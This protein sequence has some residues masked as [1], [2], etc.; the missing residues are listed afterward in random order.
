MVA[1]VRAPLFRCRPT[2][3][4]AERRWRAMG[5]D[6]QVV[7][8]GVIDQV[9]TSSAQR[10]RVELLADQAVRRVAELEG[11]WSRFLPTSEISV[12]N[13]I[14]RSVVSPETFALVDRAVL[15]WHRTDGRFDPT[16]LRILEQLGYNRS[17]DRL[18]QL[19]QPGQD[20]VGHDQQVAPNRA[21]AVDAPRGF[22]STGCG[23]IVLDPFTRTIVLPPSSIDNGPD[24]N[25]D[26]V[27]MAF[28]PGGIAKGYAADLVVEALLDAGAAGA[29]VNLGGDLRVEGTPPSGD[30]WVL[31]VGEAAWSPEPLAVLELERGAVATSTPLRRCWSK[32]SPTYRGGAG[33]ESLQ[34]H[35][36]LDAHTNRPVVNGPLLVTTI[37]GEAWWAEAA[38]TALAATP[39]SDH[40]HLRSSIDRHAAATVGPGGEIRF[41]GG[42]ERFVRSPVRLFEHEARPTTGAK[43]QGEEEGEEVGTWTR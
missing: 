38:A 17:F 22:V 2:T 40:G 19:D 39:A 36:L 27:V 15:A 37:A 12:L 33:T 1:M 30:G 26:N 41:S 21:A 23:G 42:F 4:S 28:D 5:T 20:L 6:A 9:E 25:G 31:E 10:G 16:R 11:L 32:R 35:H 34:A 14:G 3:V 29:L 18:G 8:V 43:G 13:H 7:V 24:V